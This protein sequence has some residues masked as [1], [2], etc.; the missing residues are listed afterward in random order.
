M[1]VGMNS[2]D[3]DTSWFHIYCDYHSQLLLPTPM[4][5]P[6][7]RHVSKPQSKQRC[8]AAWGRTISTTHE[9]HAY[10]RPL[11]TT[12]ADAKLPE[13]DRVMTLMLNRPATKNALTV[14]MVSEMRE[15]LATLNPAD[16]RLL[17]IQSSNPSLF[18][19]G[20]DLRER[21]TMS[22]MQVSNFLDNLR[23]LLAELEALPIPTVAVIDGYA[24]GGG[25]ELALGCDLRVGGDNTKIALPETKLGIIPGAGGTQRLTR[26]VGVAKS[27]ELIF[28]GRHVQGPEAEHIGL[29][30]IYASSP[31]SPFE[32]ALILARQILTSAPLALAAA[33]RAISSAPELSL[34]SGLDLE[35]A[36]YNGLLDTDDRQEGLKAFAEKR[37]AD[38]RGR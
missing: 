26:I 5:L 31:S 9:P 13:L 8:L 3:T 19:S 7:V 30:N 38:F 23:Q 29:L 28:T 35:R 18:C 1:H 36:V 22:P 14:Q 25:A 15:A 27:K 32:A 17:L 11:L 37:R 2:I 12:T 34:E 24:L 21:R 4:L 10:L 16:S 20:A 6:L 33:K